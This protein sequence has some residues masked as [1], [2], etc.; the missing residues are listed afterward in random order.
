MVTAAAVVSSET[1]DCREGTETERL[2][3][4]LV[5]R[6]G[7]SPEKTQIWLISKARPS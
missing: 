1:Y 2:S 6:K 7:F 4:I 5:A 3:K